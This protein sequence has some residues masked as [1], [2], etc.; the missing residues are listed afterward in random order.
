M[1]N[2]ILFLLI[3]APII[4]IFL[5]QIVHDTKEMIKNLKENF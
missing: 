2:A 3:G 4:L 1:L 5:G